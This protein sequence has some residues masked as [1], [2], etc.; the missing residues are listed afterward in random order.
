MLHAHLFACVV[1]QI[2]FV[3]R[4][5]TYI[6]FDKPLHSYKQRVKVDIVNWRLVG[7]LHFVEVDFQTDPY[8]VHV[9]HPWQES[10]DEV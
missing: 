4:S 2:N 5:Q 6:H 9:C 3:E 7:P 10:R 1:A 8:S